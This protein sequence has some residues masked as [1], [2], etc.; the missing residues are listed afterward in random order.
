MFIDLAVS[1]AHYAFKNPL[2]YSALCI[3]MTPYEHSERSIYYATIFFRILK[4]EGHG[5]KSFYRYHT[6]GF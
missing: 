3:S 4:F 5:L 6:F 2:D 1:K